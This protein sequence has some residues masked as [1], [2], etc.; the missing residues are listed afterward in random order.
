M[1][2]QVFP[3]RT[4]LRLASQVVQVEADVTQVRQE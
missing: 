4:R 2:G 3:E 1:Q